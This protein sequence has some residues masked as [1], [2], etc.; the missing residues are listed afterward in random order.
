MISSTNTDDLKFQKHEILA[1]IYHMQLDNGYHGRYANFTMLQRVI[2][3]CLSCL[4]SS[5]L[6]AEELI[7]FYWGGN[8]QI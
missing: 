4:F 6:Q 3:C 7:R 5:G 1:C 2:L 8:H